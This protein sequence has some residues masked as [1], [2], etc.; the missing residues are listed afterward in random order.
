MGGSNETKC[1]GLRMH[2][3]GGEA[4]VHDDG[5]GLKFSMDSA[6]FKKEVE[7][8]FSLLKKDGIVEIKGHSRETL[9]IMRS[10]RNF[11]A[12]IKGNTS[13]KTKLQSFIRNC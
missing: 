4:H 6:D 1:S 13:I 12:F 7:E 8:A 10:G 11:D 9:C 2:T 5:K 3:S